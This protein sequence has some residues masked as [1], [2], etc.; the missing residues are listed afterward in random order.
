MT[1]SELLVT[2]EAL[3]GVLVAASTTLTDDSSTPNT[4]RLE[5]SGANLIV[6]AGSPGAEVSVR[7]SLEVRVRNGGDDGEGDHISVAVSAVEALAAVRA[8]G[9]RGISVRLTHGT[10]EFSGPRGSALVDA[11]PDGTSQEALSPIEPSARVNAPHFADQIVEFARFAGFAD[12]LSGIGDDLEDDE[13]ADEEGDP[14]FGQPVLLLST[15]C[16]GLR[17]TT[18][19]GVHGATIQLPI[20]E[21]PPDGIGLPD[22]GVAVSGLAIAAVA[23]LLSRDNHPLR[24]AATQSALQFGIGDS[25]V[26]GA[27]RDTFMV[28]LSLKRYLAG[29][30][31]NKM[32]AD[33]EEFVSAVRDLSAHSFTPPDKGAGLAVVTLDLGEDQIALKSGVGDSTVS[34]KVFGRYSGDPLAMAFAPDLL[35]ECVKPIR[36]RDLTFEAADRSTAV[37]VSGSGLTRCVLGVAIVPV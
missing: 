16:G 34:R 22:G 1:A 17:M 23:R 28:D 10:V 6:A 26:V 2:K 3:E 8:M 18:S 32:V 30:L 35:L 7:A 33:R 19:D 13:S 37:L 21:M 4:V 24:V 31:P 29:N 5:R 36:G 9:D 11:V 27:A 15:P 20:E 14:F 25:T 12:Y